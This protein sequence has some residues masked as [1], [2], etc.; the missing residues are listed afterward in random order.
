MKT[1]GPVTAQDPAARARDTGRAA[2][3]VVLTSESVTEGHPDKVCDFIA[4]SI[5]DAYL[6]EDATSHVACEVLCKAAHVVLAGEI[7]SNPSANHEQIAR[8]AI[9]QIGYHAASEAF[10]AAS[11]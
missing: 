9:R 10:T 6:A 3:G 1:S 11:D 7:S 8:E 4:D 2:R 5:L